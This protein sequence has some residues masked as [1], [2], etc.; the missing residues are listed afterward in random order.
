MGEKK[1]YRSSL[2]SKKLIREAF[3]QLLQ[4]KDYQKITVTDIVNL[5]DINRATF[6]A[7]YPD[8]RGLLEEMENGIVMEMYS[9]LSEFDYN[10]FFDDPDPLM[11][12]LIQYLEQDSSFFQILLSSGGASSFVE[13]IKK[14]F[15]QYMSATEN[16]PESIRNSPK[17]KIRISY[18]S[19]GI[20]NI[21]IR[22]LT[23]DLLCTVD[24]IVAELCILLSEGL[25]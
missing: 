6:Y 15:E 23:G 11:R 25:K 1:E 7:H 2:R 18:F 5:A 20:V 14:L 19:G 16:I 22:W 24:D 3:V 21:L 17:Y 4:E 10:V 13:K 8:V 9:L 12:K